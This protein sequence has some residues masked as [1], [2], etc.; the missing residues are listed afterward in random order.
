MPLLFGRVEEVHRTVDIAVVGHGD[1]LLAERGDAVDEL[2]DVACAVE[3]GVFG[4]QME[5]GEFGHG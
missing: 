2:V 3:E 4:V 5:V 1:G